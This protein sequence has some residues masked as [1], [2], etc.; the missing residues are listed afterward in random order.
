MSEVLVIA[1]P[2]GWEVYDGN[3]ERQLADYLVN[4]QRGRL[5]ILTDL[6]HGCGFIHR[7]DVPSSG[8]VI[9]ATT[10]HAWYD[11]QF[12][13][14]TGTL[15]REYLVLAHG[16][17]YRDPNARWSTIAA[18]LR[19]SDDAVA[20]AHGMG[21][22]SETR[23]RVLGHARVPGRLQKGAPL[24]S[25]ESR[26]LR[27][28]IQLEVSF[29]PQGKGFGCT[30][31]LAG[32]PKTSFAVASSKKGAQAAA[33]LDMHRFLSGS[34]MLA[35]ALSDPPAAKKRKAA[36]GAAVVTSVPEPAVPPRVPKAF[37]PR[38]PGPSGIRAPGFIPARGG[39]VPGPRPVAP[40]PR[41]VAPGA[42]PVAPGARPVTPGVIPGRQTLAAR[43]QA[44]PE[45]AVA[46]QSDDGA[47]NF[48]LLIARGHLNE[49]LKKWRQPT[50][51]RVRQEG[52][53]HSPLFVASMSFQAKN[54]QRFHEM[55]QGTTKKSV[56]NELALQAG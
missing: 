23:L 55:H 56:Q 2:P 36:G 16:F 47:G 5:P 54:G 39:V 15:L 48:T 13:L 11:L 34:G 50:E 53:S 46:P 41:P 8:L 51:I 18:L 26:G 22:P 17:V 9:A 29:A 33:L 49:N 4:L 19:W 25:W 28:G 35:S 31:Q 37:A 32:V 14:V 40:G 12:Q 1:K 24:V 21:K 27:N 20:A 6:K 42:R 52:P 7:L 44:P 30:L 38:P 3:A 10:Y 43:A 45:Q